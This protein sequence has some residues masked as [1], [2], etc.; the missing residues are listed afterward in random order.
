MSLMP[1]PGGALVAW[2]AVVLAHSL[3]GVAGALDAYVHST[4]EEMGEGEMAALARV[5]PPQVR[6]CRSAGCRSAQGCSPAKGVAQL[7]VQPS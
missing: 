7:R 5:A 3:Y 4:S 1:A 2:V 6:G